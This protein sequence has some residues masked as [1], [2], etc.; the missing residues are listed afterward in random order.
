MSSRI[1]SNCDKP[2]STL[3]PLRVGWAHSLY[4]CEACERNRV[5]RLRAH[6]P[7]AVML[8][9]GAPDTAVIPERLSK[10]ISARWSKP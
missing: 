4:C 10:E 3:L 8:Q 2:E 1:C 7:G 9:Y 5:G 6:I